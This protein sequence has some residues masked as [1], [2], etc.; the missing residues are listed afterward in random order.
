MACSR[1]TYAAAKKLA[2][3]NRDIQ[4]NAVDPA[5]VSTATEYAKLVSDL[6]ITILDDSDLAEFIQSKIEDGVTNGK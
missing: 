3:L 6:L 2:R 1:E 5:A 4:T